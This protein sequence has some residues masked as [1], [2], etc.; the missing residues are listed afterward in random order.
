MSETIADRIIGLPVN[1]IEPEANSKMTSL[2][3]EP[4]GLTVY[5][6]EDGSQLRLHPTELADVMIDGRIVSGGV[7]VKAR[8]RG[9]V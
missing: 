3:V 7:V 1:K 9:T 4:T 2:I 5:V 8:K 6:F